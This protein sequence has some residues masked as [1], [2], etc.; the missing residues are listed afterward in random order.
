[1]V[2]WEPQSRN[3]G[4]E[5]WYSGSLKTQLK[6]ALLAKM[7]NT[8]EQPSSAILTN[9]FIL[10]SAACLAIPIPEKGKKML[11]LCYH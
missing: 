4:S 10:P 8:E 6:A 1:M 2:N 5:V 9:I 7:V 3:T 11:F